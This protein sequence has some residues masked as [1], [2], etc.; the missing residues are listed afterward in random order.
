MGVKSGHFK[1]GRTNGHLAVIIP[2]EEYCTIIGDNTW[3]YDPPDNINAYNHT[4]SNATAAVLAVKEAELNRKL[5]S[6]EILNGACKG[7][8]DLI[9]YR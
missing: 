4:T 5:T 8:N 7:A 6:P 1:E 3:M 2:V 9:I